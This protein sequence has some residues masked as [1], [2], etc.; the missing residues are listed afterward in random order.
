MY[1]VPILINP[2]ATFL[3]RKEPP[4]RPLTLIDNALE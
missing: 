4:K 2:S 1:A 3:S